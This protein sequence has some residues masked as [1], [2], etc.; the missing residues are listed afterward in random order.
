VD[1]RRYLGD[2]VAAAREVLG[3][4]LV[5][6]YGAGSLALDAY[7]PGRS[8]I[9]VALVGAGALD[10]DRKRALVARLRHEALPVP[11]R[12]LE[13]V[14]YRRAV[15][16]S[17][18]PD[19]GFEVELNSGPRMDFRATYDPA[20]RPAA[21][22]LFWYGLDRSILHQSRLALL[23]PPAA[24]VFA[25]LDPADLRRLLVDAIGWWMAIPTPAGDRSAPGVADAVLGACR[26]LVRVRAGVWLSKA[27]AGEHLV[28]GGDPAAPIITRA[29]AARR[30][31]PPPSGPAARAFQDRV[32]TEIARS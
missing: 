30:G 23:G 31:G 14:V 25:D 19:P 6:A 2:L 8:D 1:V 18:S 21:D 15:A 16:A 22:G 3:D 26:S 20:D 17:G 27:A 11:A 28:A 4:D 5:G 24:E 13:L 9:D 7:V 12:G 32:R 29:L 10:G